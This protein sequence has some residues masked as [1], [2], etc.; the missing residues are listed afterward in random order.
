MLMMMKKERPLRK[1]VCVAY[2]IFLSMELNIINICSIVLRSV[3]FIVYSNQHLDRPWSLHVNDTCF[4]QAPLIFQ[5]LYGHKMTGS[6]E[7]KKRTLN[8]LDFLTI[9]T[10][11]NISSIISLIYSISIQ[12]SNK[13]NDLIKNQETLPTK[14]GIIKINLKWFCQ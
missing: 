6:F 3:Y 2:V 5:K 7:G 1:K 12:L 9:V 10:F 4:F 13:C 14:E 8:L 11:F